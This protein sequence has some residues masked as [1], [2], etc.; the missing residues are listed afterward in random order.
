[1]GDGYDG[2][3]SDIPYNSFVGQTA[4]QDIV[5]SSS[6]V[7][8]EFVPTDSSVGLGGTDDGTGGAPTFNENLGTNN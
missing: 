3:I 5:I 8:S 2:L 7:Q 4:G 6:A 1:L